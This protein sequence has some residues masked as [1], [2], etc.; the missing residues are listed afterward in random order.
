MSRWAPALYGHWYAV[1][2]S[3]DVNSS[4]L[5][6][7]ILDRHVVLARLP[8]NEL[9]A[10][11]DRCPHRHAPLSAGRM[12]SDCIVCPYHGWSF[13]SDGRLCAIPGLPA[14]APVPN[15][16]VRSYATCE[17]DG[18]AWLRPGDAG[19]QRP[20]AM[21][22]ATDPATRRFQWSTSWPANI[23]DAIENFLD[24][25]HTHFIHPGLV[26][27]ETERRP[28]KAEFQPGDEGFRIDYRGASAQSGLLYRLF[29]SERTAERAYFAAPGSTRLEY[30]YANGSRILID[31]HFTPRSQDATDVHVALHVEGRWA[32]EWAVRLL[33]WP[34]LK[35][36]NDQDAGM[37]RAQAG[38]R[39]RFHSGGRASSALDIVRPELERFWSDGHWYSDG[40]CRTI[41]MM[42]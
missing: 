9:I 26:R 25:M 38:N 33:V 42:L 10:L 29:E 6:V 11:D 24:P 7:S 13:R 23:V 39:R 1:A 28:V 4:P 17:Y 8:S 21:V 12:E 31:L 3:R 27:R 32:P 34:F 35:R 2:L 36:V 41:E 37:L 15:V 16:R 40:K 22:R 19:A 5:A 30:V 14:D 20:N 18:F